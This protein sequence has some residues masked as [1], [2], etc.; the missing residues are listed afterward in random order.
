MGEAN[1]KKYES[2]IAELREEFAA[3]KSP[4]VPAEVAAEVVKTFEEVLTMP[5]PVLSEKPPRARRLKRRKR[6]PRARRAPPRIAPLVNQPRPQPAAN[7]PAEEEFAGIGLLAVQCCTECYTHRRCIITQEGSGICAHPRG[8]G[9]QGAD[10]GRPAVV[11][12]YKRVQAY[13][14]HIETDRKFAAR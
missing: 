2:V 1:E 3:G 14:A 9:L 12:R 6:P 10:L 13:L 5:A 8:T 7:R 4:D 11:Q